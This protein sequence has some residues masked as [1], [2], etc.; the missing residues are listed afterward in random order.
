MTNFP[1]PP[2]YEVPTPYDIAGSANWRNKADNC[3]TVYRNPETVDVLVQKI[4]VKEVGRIGMATFKY[5]LSTGEF[6]PV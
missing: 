5:K 1:R 3:L 4:R 6:V 2:L